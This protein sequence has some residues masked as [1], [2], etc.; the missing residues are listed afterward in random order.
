MYN[1]N[2]ILTLCGS[3]RLVGT[4][5]MLTENKKEDACCDI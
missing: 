2:D 1:Y 4:V 3:I 5:K